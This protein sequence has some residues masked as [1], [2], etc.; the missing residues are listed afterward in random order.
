MLS[1]EKTDRVIISLKVI[2]T[3]QQGQRLCV[4]NNQFSVYYD[5][6]GQAFS[7]WAYG[8][9]RW[10]NF[11]DVSNVMNEAFCILGTYTNLLSAPHD[12]QAPLSCITS[13]HTLT[14]EIAQASTG[15]CNLK[16][17]YATDP[18]MVATLD[19]LT[20]RANAEV[21]KAQAVLTKCGPA[22]PPPAS[23]V[24]VASKP[25]PKTMLREASKSGDML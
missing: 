2:A 11:E 23:P 3:L 8:E 5:G 15:L 25:T 6:W 17:T 19:V 20:E 12:A 13:V 9:N 7:R 21:A 18:L 16:Q 14:K 1:L 22:P 24:P 10:V 4:R